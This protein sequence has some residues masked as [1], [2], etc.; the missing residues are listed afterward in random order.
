MI[1]TW[2]TILLGIQMTHYKADQLSA[3][4]RKIMRARNQY[5]SICVNVASPLGLIPGPDKIS[6]TPDSH[7]NRPIPQKQR[8]GRTSEEKRNRGLRDLS[9]A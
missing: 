7:Q 9:P 4:Y 3:I 2:Y 6:S 1:R 5:Y 8:F